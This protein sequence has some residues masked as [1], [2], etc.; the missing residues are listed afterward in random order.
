MLNLL[1]NAAKFVPKH[2]GRVHVELASDDDEVRVTVQDNG[3]GIAPDFMPFVFDKFRQGGDQQD[4]PQ[5][6]GLG[7]PISRQ[8][9]EHFGGRMWAE[10][11]PGREQHLTFTLPRHHDRSRVNTDQK[12]G[13]DVM[14]RKD[15]DRRRRGEHRHLARIPDETRGLRGV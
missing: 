4:R 9:I 1:S 5:G 13:E 12:W 3:P 6:T 7:L 14:A 8:I 2:E 10:S 11:P 15:P